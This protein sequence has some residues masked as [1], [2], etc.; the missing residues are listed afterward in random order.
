M[1]HYTPNELAFECSTHLYCE[2]TAVPEDVSGYAFK[3]SFVRV[4]GMINDYGDM[5]GQEFPNS[6]ENTDEWKRRELEKW[7]GASGIM[8]STNSPDCS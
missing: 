1:L 6:L 4:R 3:Q 2:C 8:L 7:Q 5:A